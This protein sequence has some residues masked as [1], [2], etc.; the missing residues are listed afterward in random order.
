M[1]CVS[2]PPAVLVVD[3]NRANILA[4]RAILERGPPCRVLTA[5]SGR[6]ALELAE[7]EELAVVLLDV[8]MPL[9]DGPEVARR[10]KQ[11]ERTRHLPIV[12]VTAGDHCDE[13]RYDD[14][15]CIEKPV[16][17]EVVRSTVARLLARPRP[18][19]A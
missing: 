11:S 15:D 13:E 5:T 2:S 19:R 4:L 8:N 14:V 3:D 18:G 12:F 1:G 16:E 10:L 17:P 9:M 7:R 6:E